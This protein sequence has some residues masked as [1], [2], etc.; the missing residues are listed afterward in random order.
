MAAAATLM[1]LPD[2]CVSVMARAQQLKEI[3]RFTI[4]LLPASGKIRPSPPPP[5]PASSRRA[6]ACVPPDETEAAG[7]GGEGHRRIFTHWKS[8]DK[9][10][11]E[12]LDAFARRFAWHCLKTEPK[13]GYSNKRTHPP[14]SQCHHT[15]AASCHLQLHPALPLQLPFLH[16]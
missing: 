1:R 6:F 16:S 10:G 14:R 3:S 12:S 7:V 15:L 8:V 5:P 13:F 11:Y 2:I 4:H 9:N